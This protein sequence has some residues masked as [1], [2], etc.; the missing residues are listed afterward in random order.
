VEVASSVDWSWSS[1]AA[2]H[3]TTSLR[4]ESTTAATTAADGAVDRG[5]SE[6]RDA[7]EDAFDTATSAVEDD[8]ETVEEED[9]TVLAILLSPPL[10]LASPSSSPVPVAMQS[11]S[12]EDVDIEEGKIQGL[13]CIYSCPLKGYG[14]K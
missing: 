12:H 8:V 14:P 10:P 7:D 9:D 4:R 13:F 1:T 6:G 5:R 11:H 2:S 3:A